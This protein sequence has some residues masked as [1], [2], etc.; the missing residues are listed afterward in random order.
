MCFFT[1]KLLRAS[2]YVCVLKRLVGLQAQNMVC[3]VSQNYLTMQLSPESHFTELEFCGM[4]F[5]KYYSRSILQCH[6]SQGGKPWEER[7]SDFVTFPLALALGW[8]K[9]SQHWA[10]E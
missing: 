8:Q 6:I 1:G 9:P 4:H 5:R 10:A 7:G 3:L 2:V